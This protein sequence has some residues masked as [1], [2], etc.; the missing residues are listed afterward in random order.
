MCFKAFVSHRITA[1]ECVHLVRRGLNT[2]S[3][4]HIYTYT[5]YLQGM[6]VKFVYE[7]HL[8]KVKVTGKRSKTS[9]LTM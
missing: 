7:G 2:T 1:C 9:I 3:E 5:V 6:R 4:V 8:V